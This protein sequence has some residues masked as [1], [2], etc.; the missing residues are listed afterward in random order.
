MTHANPVRHLLAGA[1]CAGLLAAAGAARAA[2]G[3]AGVLLPP[4]T[5]PPSGEHHIGKVVWADL[6]TPN[7][8]VAR[9]FYGALFG[10]T[11]RAVSGDPN[12][13]LVLLDG[14]AIGG[15]YQKP[16]PPGQSQ[17]SSWLTFLA[18]R[19]V[20]ATQQSAVQMGA[21]LLS[22]PHSY[23]RRGRQ[24]VLA[25]PDGAVFAILAADGGDPPDYLAA[26]GA[27]I[28]TS[29]FV[30]NPQQETAFYKR[31]F[32]YDVYDMAADGGEQGDA[33]HYILSSEDYARVGLNALPADAS[34]RHP[35]WLNFIRVTDAADT[36]TKAVA[37][38][39][40]ILVE[41]RT[42]RHGGRLAVLA[43]PSGA[44]FGVMEWTESDSKQEPQ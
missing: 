29:M 8:D 25:D 15:I 18:V 14:E 36:A 24:A 32:G 22:P 44:P 41:P 43:D 34:R 42:D 13:S 21:K 7:L 30:S 20:R 38:G 19:D 6:V 1:L 35:H 39:G 4:I 31:L 3:S 2:P 40:R 9:T 5:Q 27:W 33:Q 11:F 23:P 37:L 17:Q 16:L 12:Y 10:W 26:S 28:W